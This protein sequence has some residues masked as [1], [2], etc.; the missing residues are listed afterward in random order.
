LL[1]YQPFYIGGI[2]DVGRAKE[3]AFGAMFAFIATF[4]VSLLVCFRDS[5]I[6][7]RQLLL[8]RHSYDQVPPISSVESY[9]INLGDLPASAIEHAGIVNRGSSSL[10]AEEEEEDVVVTEQELVS[11]QPHVPEGQLLP[12]T[13]V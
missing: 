8:E 4:V 5:R 11:S 2:E 1:I 7:R 10:M 9:E 12:T 13:H 6:K 3:S